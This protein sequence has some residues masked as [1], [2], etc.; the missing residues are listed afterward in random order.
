MSV[1]LRSRVLQLDSKGTED[2]FCE[3]KAA[4]KESDVPCPEALNLTMLH[5]IRDYYFSRRCAALQLTLQM[6]RVARD[7]NH[8]YS[9]T[10]SDCLTD[11]FS[12]IEPTQ[13]A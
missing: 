10:A 9:A 8:V 1:T 2:I 11:L 5:R 4:A 6:C 12:T 7:T 13:E 3:Y